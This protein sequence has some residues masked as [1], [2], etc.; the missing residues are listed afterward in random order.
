MFFHEETLLEFH[1]ST[2]HRSEVL[3]KTPVNRPVD[4]QVDRL[5]LPVGLGQKHPDRFQPWKEQWLRNYI[6]IQ[7]H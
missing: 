4:R 6:S 2:P 3:I 7:K 5:N 1:F